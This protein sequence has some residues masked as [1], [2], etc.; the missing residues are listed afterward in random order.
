MEIEATIDSDMPIDEAHVDETCNTQM[1]ICKKMIL[2]N[3][4]KID[5]TSYNNGYTCSI[6][7]I[8]SKIA[9]SGIKELDVTNVS[10]RNFQ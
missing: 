2:S 5:M 1:E 4:P 10:K 3:S 6:K 8:N 7:S 9:G